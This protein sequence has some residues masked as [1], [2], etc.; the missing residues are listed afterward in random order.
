MCNLR[1]IADHPNLQGYLLYLYPEPGIA[2]T[3][4]FDHIKLH[5]YYTQAEINPTRIA[6]LV[7]FST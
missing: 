7:P 2:A 4:T 3:V 1:R 5:Y 6:P